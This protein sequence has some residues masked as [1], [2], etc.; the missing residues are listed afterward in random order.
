MLEE[1]DVTRVGMFAIPTYRIRFKDHEKYKQSMIDYMEN[2]DGYKNGSV[3]TLHFT[4]PNLHKVEV[5]KP[6]VDF[7]QAGLEHAMKDCGFVP[8]IKM[9]G[10]WGTRHTEGGFHHEH[11]HH[12]SRWGGVYYLDGTPN[13]SGT[14]F[15]NVHRYGQSIDPARITNRRQ[16][17]T[18]RSTVAFEEGLLVIFPAWLPHNTA[19]NNLAKSGSVRKILSF[20]SMPVGP[21]NMDPFDR[22]HYVD[23][24]DLKMQDRWKE[25]PV[26]INSESV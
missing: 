20:N 9:T 21:T 25:D 13:N 16:R 23:P 26:D 6:F 11:V 24:T 10:L 17:I 22:Y 5:F 12:N 7:V 3:P 18:Y 4:S 2:E 1:N 14:I 15:H 8:S 19:R